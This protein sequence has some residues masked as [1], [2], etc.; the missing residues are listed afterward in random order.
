MAP[1]HTDDMKVRAEQLAELI[2]HHSA[3][4]HE[5]DAPEI[6]DE[7]Y[8]SLVREYEAL[9][10]EYPHLAKKDSPLTK[11]GG[12]PSAAFSKMRH[13]ARQWSFDNAFSA[14]ELGAW[15]ERVKKLLAA[16]GVSDPEPAYVVEHKIDGLKVILEYNEGKLVRAATRGDGVTGE[17]VTHTAGT[18]AD[19][20][21]TIPDSHNLIVI[22]EAWLPEKELIR[23]NRER[24]ATGEPLFANTRNA[25]AGSLRQLD[26]E[27]T[28][29]RKL[30]YFAYDIDRLGDDESLPD[31]Q[32]GE[33][34]YLREQGFTVNPHSKRLNAIA[35]V[36]A[37][38][39]TW[40]ERRGKLPYGVD[41]VVLKV[42]EV[43]FQNTLGYTAKAPRF[44]IAFKFPAEEVTT[45][46]VEI[47][48]QV[49]RTG[50]VTPV[51]VM[52]PVRVAGSVV[53]HATLHNE[54]RIAELDA[55]IG[56][57]VVLRKAG[58]VIPEIVRVIKEL[59]PKGATP[60]IFPR[61]VRECGGDGAIER[62]PGTAAYR[63]VAKDSDTLHRA[64]LYHFV[65]R[66]ALNMDGIGPRIIDQL[67]EASLLSSFDD[68]FML[69]KGDFLTLEGFKEKSAENAI[70]AI[71]QVRTTTF[72]RLLVAL[73][74]DHVGV[75][76]AELIART[77]KTPE[78]LYVATEA[79]LI[80]IDGIGDIVA[81]SVFLW[82]K[83]A[84]NRKLFDALCAQL[85]FEDTVSSDRSLEG[86]SFVFTGTLERR[87]RDEAGNEVKQR[88]GVVSGSVSRQ[89]SY[90]VA[91]SDPGSKVAK[92]AE[93]GVSILDEDA[94]EALLR[95][96]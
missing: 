12:A 13:R 53:R 65:S 70:S 90:V 25:A 96:I 49:G 79:D 17:D 60:Y 15:D 20:P 75:T 26:P 58:D 47:R 68:F 89:T 51:A 67:V 74:I 54:D 45:E 86:K 31:T 40:S 59:R 78:R 22:G 72:A 30:R 37:Y 3:Q 63:C 7:A 55:R 82:F 2:A 39:E 44:G 24:E 52:K 34:E 1:K 61:T 84:H 29:S 23:I 73:S 18:I 88:G 36:H 28:R 32:W 43:A 21:E 62:I 64:R 19:I 91:G 16:S 93:L 87:S 35:E 8:D 48:L 9:V 14:E 57:T 80:A 41:G 69:T 66:S 85:V 42:D 81:Q 50:V 4:Y 10:R 11:V 27:I 71:N 83:E 33:L 76:T 77:F 38:Y 6:S 5:H 92:A 56:D 46:L 94:F 95:D